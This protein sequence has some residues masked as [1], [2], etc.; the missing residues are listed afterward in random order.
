M[1]LFPARAFLRTG[2]AVRYE[3]SRKMPP[4]YEFDPGHVDA[5]R[6][7][8]LGAGVRGLNEMIYECQRSLE[9]IEHA[10]RDVDVR[11]WAWAGGMG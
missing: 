10:R 6:H 8:N 11:G 2:R 9:G 4:I 5:I 1:P 3:S 7:A